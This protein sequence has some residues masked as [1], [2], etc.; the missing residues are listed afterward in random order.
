MNL[1][2]KAPIRPRSKLPTYD[3]VAPEGRPVPRQCP[4]GFARVAPEQ[5]TARP[6][7]SPRLRPRD[8]NRGERPVIAA[9]EWDGVTEY[10]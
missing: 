9:G 10:E 8:R 7:M 2:D 3:Q 6:G 1:K 5:E 4:P